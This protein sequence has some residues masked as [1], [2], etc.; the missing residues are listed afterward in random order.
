MTNHFLLLHSSVG[1]DLVIED[2][3]LLTPAQIAQERKALI[4]EGSKLAWLADSPKDLAKRIP[5]SVF[6]MGDNV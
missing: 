4:E 6:A 1:A 5:V 3:E 2:A